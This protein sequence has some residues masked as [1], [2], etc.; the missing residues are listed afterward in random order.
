MDSK[1]IMRTELRDGI[2]IVQFTTPSIGAG[3]DIQEL[4]RQLHII[5][6]QAMPAKLVVDFAMVSFFSSQVLG[7]LVD[8]WRRLKDCGGKV[9]VSG[10]NPNLTRVFRITNLDKIFEFYPNTDSAVKA[11]AQPHQANG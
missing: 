4:S 6:E 8:I 10:I 2:L 3:G 1:G 7:M 11:L 9:V 5:I